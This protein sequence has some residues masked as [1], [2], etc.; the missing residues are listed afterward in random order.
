MGRDAGSCLLVYPPS[1]RLA[2]VPALFNNNRHPIGMLW[3]DE[4]KSEVEKGR[5][6]EKLLVCLCA[7]VLA[8]HRY[9]PL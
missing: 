8:P 7:A 6:H 4:E 3:G 5:V 1:R 2:L 9:I